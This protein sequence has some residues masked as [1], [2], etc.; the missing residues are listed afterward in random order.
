[1]AVMQSGQIQV[2]QILGNILM[3]E[4]EDLLMA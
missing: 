3:A 4:Q 2:S 1:V